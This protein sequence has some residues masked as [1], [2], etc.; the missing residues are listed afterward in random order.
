MKKGIVLLA[1]L[2]V[3]TLAFVACSGNNDPDPTPTPQ[4]G[5]PTPNVPVPSPPA[6]GG[7][8]PAPP[9]PG[10]P[11][12]HE[13]PAGF[14]A[15]HFPATDLGGITLRVQGFP[16]PYHEDPFYAERNSAWRDFVETRFNVRLDFTRNDLPQYV[17]DWNMV[18]DAMEASI[19]AGDPLVHLFAGLNAGFWFMSLAR[20]DSFVPLTDYVRENFPRSWW[21][22]RA[23][24]EGEVLGFSSG[25]DYAWNTFVY[26]R[27]LINSVGM[28]STP[29]EMIVNGRW[30][31]DDFIDYAVELQTLLPEGHAAFTSSSWP[32]TLVSILGSVNGVQIVDPRTRVPNVVEEAFLEVLRFQ[33]RII[34]NGVTP[35]PIFNPPPPEG[36]GVEPAGHWSIPTGGFD[37]GTVAMRDVPPWGFPSEFEFGVMLPPW[38]A[39]RV[40][41][42]AS[43]RWQDLRLANP[44]YMLSRS[45][46]ASTN[47]MVR[48]T[49]DIVTPEV[50]VNLFF[51]YFQNSGYSYVNAMERHRFGLPE[52][53]YV[54][55]ALQ[56]MHTD[57]DAEMYQ[58]WV[59]EPMWDDFQRA[60][61]MNLQIQVDLLEVA[62]TG[63]DPF[64]L[65]DAH[66]GRMVAGARTGRTLDANVLPEWMRLREDEFIAAQED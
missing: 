42:P 10:V 12:F 13:D 27:D 57:L 36:T 18:P 58:F 47:L 2:L 64:P 55:G 50:F 52:L 44:G 8:D 49:P 25:P 9:P 33:S 16:D 61:V 1:L 15:S 53:P 7:N 35:T 46:D 41:F 60:G 32:I 29:S 14:I 21:E 11:D 66:I 17:G 4:G 63:I 26:N 59:A 43:G 5:V 62:A 51:S 54:G 65:M 3:F 20:N 40:T 23:E 19:A 24:F 38:N 30:S 6:G 31:W 37:T 45:N 34:A 28:H 22:F 48:G 56:H 39:D